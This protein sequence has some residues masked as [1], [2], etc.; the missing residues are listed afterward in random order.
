MRVHRL[1][2][3]YKPIKLSRRHQNGRKS[4]RIIAATVCLLLVGT[5][6]INSTPAAAE[7]V[8]GVS[9]AW[10]VSFGVWLETSGL[11]RWLA[12][13]TSAAPR[14]E[15]Q[16]ERNARIKRLRISPDQVTAR[17]GE[18]VRFAAIAYGENDDT[19]GG[20][21]FRWRSSSEKE[22][23]A[24]I[25]P[26]GEFSSLTHGTFTVSATAAGRT[27]QTIVTVLEGPPPTKERNAAVRHFSTRNAPPDPQATASKRTGNAGNNR[28]NVFQK[29]SFNSTS[30]STAPAPLPQGSDTY[31]WNLNNYTTADD[32][33][34]QVGDPPGT[35]EDGGAGNGNFQIAAPVLSLPGRGL[36]VNLALTYN[37]HLWH[38]AGTNITYDIDRGWPAPGWSFGF[39][40]MADI[41]DG[42][43]IVVEPDGT[44][45]GFNGTAT[46]PLANSSFSG[47]TND[48]TFID[49]ACVRTN[50]VIVYGS[51][52]FPN[53]IKILYGAAGDGAIYP[54]FII[55]PNGNFINVTYRNNAGPQIDTVTDTMGRVINFHYD[56]TTNL[57]TAVTAPQYSGGTARTLVRLHY[58]QQLINPGF[59]GVTVNIRPPTTRWLLDAIYY[60]ASNTGFWFGESN[61]FLANYGTIARVLERREMTHSSGGLTDMGS[62]TA[63]TMTTDRVYAWTTS[64]NKPPTYTSLTESW[65]YMDTAAVVTSYLVDQVSSPRTTTVTL[66]NGI[67]S[68][69]SSHNAPGLFNDGLVFKDETFDVDGTTLLT[70]SEVQWEQGDYNSPR[71][72]YTSVTTK[73]GAN[74]VT[75]GTE[76]IYTTSPSFNQAIEVKTFDFG[77]VWQGSSNV[78]LKK[79]VTT[80]ENS[81]NYTNRHIFNLPKTVGVYSGAG[82]RVSLTEYT[83]DGG[84]LDDTPNVVQHLDEYDPYAPS[85]LQP[86][87]YITQCSGCPPCSCVPVWIPPTTSNP[88]N[89]QTVYRGNVTQVKTFAEAVTPDQST[90]VVETRS[91]DMTG[92]MNESSPSCCQLTSIEFT[93]TNQYAYPESVTRG[94]SSDVLLKMKTSA[95]Y[96][97]NTGLVTSTT[98]ANGRTTQTTHFPSSLRPERRTLATAAHTDYSYD[99]VAMTVTERTYLGAHSG[100]TGLSN[101]TVKHM[102]GRGKVRMQSALGASSV[103]DYVD[104]KY[105]NMGRLWQQSAPYRT[106][107]TPQL[108]T[109]SYDSQGRT[110]R[111]TAPDGSA[112]ESYYNEVDFEPGGYAPTRPS[113]A[114]PNVS[115]ESVLVRDAWGRERWARQDAQGRMVEVVEPDPSG[116]GSVAS[117]GLKT[118]YSY[119]TLGNLTGVVQG[120]QTRSFKYDSLGRMTHQK[121][122]E[123]QAMLNDAGAYV[124]SGGTWSEVFTYDT[125]SNLTSR[126]DARGAK[127][128]YN[129]NIV[130]NDNQTKDPLNRVRFVTW[131]TSDCLDSNNPVLE[132]KSLAYAYRTKTVGTQTKD[133]TQIESITTTDVGVESFTFDTEGRVNSS[134]VT[135]NNRLLYPFTIT[136]VYDA[137]SRITDIYYPAQYGSGD[138]VKIVHQDYDVASRLSSLTYDSLSFASNIVYNAASRT[139]QMKVGVSGTNQIIENYGYGT[140]T[141]LLDSQTIARSSTPSTYLLDLSYE[142]TDANSK[143]TGQLKKVLNNLNHNKDRSYTYD[144]IRRLKEAKGGPSASPL[145]T[146]TYVYDRYGNRTSSYRQRLFREE[147]ASWWTNSHRSACEEHL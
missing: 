2:S 21:E 135:L 23:M 134:T 87:H 34:S 104:S 129:Y 31:G 68:V 63:G 127:T 27:A 42:G 56:S 132:A 112:T 7:T 113:A 33:G 99:D 91:Y 15:T 116:S 26:A 4:Q 94:S 115:G 86:G 138:N 142:Y 93:S 105:D 32:P 49:Y 62:M 64:S 3:A 83:Y 39:G 96:N 92:N 95:A 130:P 125:K 84:T 98:D 77:Y 6:L 147:R 60:P 25:S 1:T 17:V 81:S 140:S 53:G 117:S 109:I 100:D 82:T 13:N 108:T 37:S 146:Q 10:P 54:T 28:R 136:K 51:A 101:E 85:Y 14:P 133:L 8:V 58:Q 128:I 143:S 124:S 88:Y 106:G 57:L 30:A 102:N 144:A 69:Q 111:V 107:Q 74:Y 11:K 16:P 19:I 61:S 75:T 50:G 47:R 43:A 72:Q 97:F 122:A 90:A 71:P 55:D 79:T 44:R 9:K 45:H 24:S 78:L 46:G 52:N 5:L 40:E 110:V 73:Q 70:K 38:K 89:P 145:W 119:D 103:L 126:K 36:N 67:K 48:G 41:G 80:Y 123:A 139:T 66:P 35:P 59:S 22:G 141:G 65:A 76:F 137:L 118:T 29:A 20:V 12:G 120:S 114:T 18:V 131:D 121:L